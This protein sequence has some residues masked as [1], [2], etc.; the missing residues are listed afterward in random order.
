MVVL[1][2]AATV[3]KLCL[4]SDLMRKCLLL[5]LLDTLLPI[6]A[7]PTSMSTGTASSTATAP[8]I[9]G[10][11][12]R[13]RPAAFDSGQVSVFSLG[14]RFPKRVSVITCAKITPE[15]SVTTSAALPVC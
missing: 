6:L 12:A 5:V 7:P 2:L 11:L 4:P 9:A 10:Q 14:Q 3:R 8:E 1:A 15:S 13:T